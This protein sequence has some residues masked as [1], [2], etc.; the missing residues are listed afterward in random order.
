MKKKKRRFHSKGKKIT[1]PSVMVPNFTTTKK[2]FLPLIQFRVETIFTSLTS[3]TFLFLP[4][5]LYE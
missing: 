3:K 5:S 2:L 1:E 4:P